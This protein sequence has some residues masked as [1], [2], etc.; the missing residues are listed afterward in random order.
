M[1][2]VFYFHPQYKEKSLHDW[3]Y[4]Q[5][6]QL[7]AK[8]ESVS[9]NKFLQSGMKRE[10]NYYNIWFQKP[11]FHFF[12]SRS[13]CHYADN[14]LFILFSIPDLRVFHVMKG[15]HKGFI[16]YFITQIIA[17]FIPYIHVFMW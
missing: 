16:P 11:K 7:E 17:F 10:Y 12:T 14:F 5:K 8:L 2:Y 3:S 1:G 9:S 15:F 6:F 13:V 4:L